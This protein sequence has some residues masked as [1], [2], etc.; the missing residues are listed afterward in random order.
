MIQSACAFSNELFDRELALDERL[1]AM[2]DRATKRPINI[3]AMKDMMRQTSAARESEQPKKIA[4]RSA[5]R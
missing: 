3:K 4:A 1:N 2:I 5:L